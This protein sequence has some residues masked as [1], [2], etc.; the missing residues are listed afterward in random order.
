MRAGIVHIGVGNFHRAHEALVLDRCLH[1]PGHEDWGI[2]GVGLGKGADAA[3]KAKDLEEQ[4]CLYT[5][6][7]CAPDGARS[8]RVIGSIIRYLHAPANP[9]AVLEALSDSGI[10]IVSLTITE[11]GYNICEAT[12]EFDL[13]HPDIVHDLGRHDAPRT[14]FGHIVEALARRRASGAGPF[15]IMTCDNLRHNGDVAKLAVLSFARAKDPGLGDWIENHVTFPN[16]MVDRIVPAITPEDRS[17][18]NASMGIDDRLP[19]RAET[20][21]QWVMEDRFCSGR[22][23]LAAAGVELRDDVRDFEVIK[24]R[25]LNGSHVLLCFPAL[26]LGYREVHHALSNHSL[27][28][29]LDRFMERDVMPLLVAPSGVSLHDYKSMVLDR[30][31]NPAIRDQLLRICANGAVKLPTF[32]FKTLAKCLDQGRDIDRF[33]FVLA[34]FRRYLRGRDEAGTVYAVDEPHISPAEQVVAG[35]GDPLDTLRIDAFASL[36][37]AGNRGFVRRYL[38]FTDMI[39]AEGVSIA[40]E[41]ASAD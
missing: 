17:T 9:E 40:L 13:T 34:C 32:L 15:T 41:A 18:L 23:D 11:G 20:F 31:A 33:A 27:A 3:R 12:G 25:M 35:S 19:V 24:G 16:S 10:R 22:P 8:S 28:K 36:D 37:L 30:F 6:T 7:E 38:K 1:L 4:S 39:A 26:L 2:V 29:L 14:A 5:V 21:L